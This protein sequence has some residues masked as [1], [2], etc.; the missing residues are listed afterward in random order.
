MVPK[1]RIRIA[2]LT[3]GI[4]GAAIGSFWMYLLGQDPLMGI[5]LLGLLIAFFV[6]GF[7]CFFVSIWYLNFV[8]EKNLSRAFLFGSLFACLAGAISGGVTG[9]ISTFNP[10]V[11]A[12][13]V[14]IGILTGVAYWILSVCIY[15]IYKAIRD[16][17]QETRT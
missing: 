1:N 16:K 7:S 3:T 8:V 2:S 10:V 11:V 4:A 6:S 15:C 13:G 17:F 9:F 12:I 5:T 14:V